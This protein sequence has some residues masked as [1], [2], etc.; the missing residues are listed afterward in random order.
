MLGS[1]V[2]S[3][4]LFLSGAIDD[5]SQRRVLIAGYGSIGRRHVRNL[6]SLGCSQL[7]FFRTHRGAMPDDKESP[8]GEAAWPEVYELEAAWSHQPRIAVISESAS[9]SHVEVALAAAR[10]GCDLLIEKPLSDSLEGCEELADVVRQK[11]S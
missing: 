1:A 10:N 8:I 5:K 11:D 2:A 6:Q 7:M 9:A 3:K 4:G